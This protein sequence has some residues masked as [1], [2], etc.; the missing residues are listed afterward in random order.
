MGPLRV[1]GEQVREFWS[2][3][4][5]GCETVLLPFIV[6][7]EVVTGRRLERLNK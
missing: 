7:Y 5:Q 3:F 2:G 6:V 1:W 4:A